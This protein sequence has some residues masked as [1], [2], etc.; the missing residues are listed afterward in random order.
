MSQSDFVSRGQALV[1]AGQ[2]QEA[3]KVCR[4]GLLGRPTT[5]EGRVVLGSALLALKRYDEVL[6]EMR[7]A[8]ELDHSAVPAHALKAEALLK[9]GDHQAAADALGE[10]QKLAPGDPRIQQ[11][12][13]DAR[14]PAVRSSAVAFVGTGDTKHYPNHASGDGSASSD[15]ENSESFT[16]PT[17][18]SSPGAPRRTAS[19]MATAKPK[20]P[21]LHHDP[22]P[23]RSV[24]AVGDK[25]G[26]V[27]VDP[28]RDG[29]EL[30][31]DLDFDDLAAPPP[32]TPAP[33]AGRG[34]IMKSLKDKRPSD[35]RTPT[36]DLVVDDDS[37]VLEVENAASRPAAPPGRKG[38][39]AVRNAVQMPSGPIDRGRPPLAQALAGHPHAIHPHAPVPHAPVPPVP[40]PPAP[41][42]PRGPIAA[43][44]PTVAAMHPPP[45]PS[46]FHQSLVPPSLGGPI[47]PA[48]PAQVPIAQRQTIIAA[49]Q[50]PP[51][52]GASSPQAPPDPRSLAAA[53]EPTMRPV[54]MDP[55][56][57]AML[58]GM[59]VEQPQAH[60]SAQGIDPHLASGV[61]KKTGV[62]KP[63]SKW[64]I[65][66]WLLVG[67]VVIGGGVFAGFQ[68]RALRLDKQVAVARSHATDLAKS[69]TFAGWAAARDEL[70]R[71]VQA[72]G[73]HENQ[74]AL[75]RA[76]AMIAFEF[77]EGL[78]DAKVTLDALA[79]KT[80]LDANLAAA[81]LALAQSDPKAAGLAADAAL[82]EAPNDPA[83]NYVAGQVAL[84]SGDLAEA[85]KKGKIAVDK[86]PRPLYAVGLARAYTAASSWT[87]AD[88]AL[89]RASAGMADQP[90]AVIERAIVL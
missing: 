7:V 57:Q 4:L 16:K 66:L 75:A 21:G 32:A 50:P 11:L 40:L 70:S 9:K 14:G 53:Q 41:Q 63:R 29:V 35:R 34:A 13:A 2:F 51:N 84:A 83:A 60:P 47:L 43:A 88:A 85:I 54:A 10:A 74:A 89:A 71:I 52:W 87:E 72:S 42:P 68:I 22:T 59:P 38:A 49:A 28:D 15:P 39:T 90:S 8:L 64:Q 61:I 33:S 80:G 17:S 1:A 58:A 24:L 20:T 78:N 19:G 76:R 23:P 18:L 27:E 62:R 25:S 65:A 30:D 37:D 44:L 56:L 5:V 3:V 69:D 55:G 31:D 48:A 12:L 26:T 79:D 46:A 77:D 81:Y 86:D 82:S 36:M 67:I 6:A 45:P 73:T